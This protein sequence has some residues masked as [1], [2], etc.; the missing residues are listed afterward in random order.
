MLKLVALLAVPLV[1]A[2]AAPPTGGYVY[3]PTPEPAATLPK[4]KNTASLPATGGRRARQQAAAWDANITPPVE[5]SVRQEM[6]D[7]GSAQ[8]RN[9][10]VLAGEREDQRLVCGEVNAKNGY[11]GYVGFKPF[12]VVVQR[13]A[14]TGEVLLSEALMIPAQYGGPERRL[15]S[16][17][18][19]IDA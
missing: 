18:C 7:P 16:S 14:N 11:G 3:T 8:F 2:C 10:R 19:N 4:P 9:L 12:L 1:A 13:G 6:R 17:K 5:S 15:I